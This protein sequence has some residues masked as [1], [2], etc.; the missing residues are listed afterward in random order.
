LSADLVCPRVDQARRDAGDH[1]L[2]CGTP[3][4]RHGPPPELQ[5]EVDKE[6]EQKQ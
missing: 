6:S 5:S 4:Q 3:L 2:E 1:M